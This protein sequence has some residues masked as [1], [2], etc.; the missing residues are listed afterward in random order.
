LS[1]ELFKAMTGTAITHVP[2]KGSFPA[3]VDLVGGQVSMMFDN[4]PTAIPHIR[5]GRIH[6]L[7]VTSA[8]RSPSLP[9]LPTIAESGLPGY[10]VVSWFG[11]LGPA[12][13]PR[14]LIDRLHAE[15]VKALG[16]ADV[17][18][19][20][21]GLGA[22]IVG[23]SPAEFTAYIKSEIIKWEKVVRVSGARAE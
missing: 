8:Q 21:A 1:G 3:M 17:K 22:V 13:M 18:D 11:V 2:Y 7:G 20:L 12:A 19:R 5:T 15:I 14:P 4:L 10:D 16:V 9:D 6:A 23:S